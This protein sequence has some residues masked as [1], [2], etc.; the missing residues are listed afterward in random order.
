MNKAAELA[1]QGKLDDAIALL[2]GKNDIESAIFLGEL[3]EAKGT[4]EDA[5]ALWR[6][7][8]SSSPDRGHKFRLLF[9][10]ASALK[11]QG[12][13]LTREAASS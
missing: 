13:V 11:R 7:A 9:A 5:L 10:I 8:A 12:S 3:L 1:E 2:K 4:P 6:K